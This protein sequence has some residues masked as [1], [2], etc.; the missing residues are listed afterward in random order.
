MKI[1]S[2][3][4]TGLKTRA[5]QQGGDFL[6]TGQKIFITNGLQADTI[7]VLVNTDP[8]LGAYKNKSQIVVPLNSPG[9]RRTKI[10]KLGALSSDMAVIFF[11]EVRVPLK[12]LIG[13]LNQG[14]VYQMLQFQEER[15]LIVASCISLFN[16]FSLSIHQ[17]NFLSSR[18]ALCCSKT[19]YDVALSSC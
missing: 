19:K 4:S 15:M 10:D 5:V 8:K 9:V 3:L 11:D 16:N 2:I 6:I 1:D 12:N 17:I 7:T 13:E 14:F 18:F